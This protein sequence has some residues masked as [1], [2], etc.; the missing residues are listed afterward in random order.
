MPTGYEQD[1]WK[2]VR[3][4]AE[5]SLEQTKATERRNDLLEVQNRL[6]E[7]IATVLER[8]LERGVPRL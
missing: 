7:R 6:L 5:Q 4:L 3:V 8:L 1:L 2:A